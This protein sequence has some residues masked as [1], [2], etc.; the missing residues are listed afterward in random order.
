VTALHNI[1]EGDRLT[2]LNQVGKVQ[3]HGVIR[4]D[5]EVGW[6]R[7]PLNPNYGQQCAL[8]HQDRGQRHSTGR[9]HQIGHKR[10]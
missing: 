4:C 7:Y 10:Q 9:L 6:H 8:G 2:I 5:K 3:W 1:C